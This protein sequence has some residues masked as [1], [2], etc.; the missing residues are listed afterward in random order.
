V[1]LAP[2]QGRALRVNPAA[3]TQKVNQ[4]LRAHRAGPNPVLLVRA[5]PAWSHDPLLTTPDGV[6]LRVV[7]CVSAL[8][9]WEQVSSA[10]DTGRVLLT[11]L[12][13]GQ[14]GTG[15]LSQVFR[16]RILTIESWDLIAECFGAQRLDPRLEAETWAGEA[17]IDAMPPGGWP[18]LAGTVLRRDL[19]LRYLAAARLGLDRLKLPP[20]DL[21][22]QALLLWSTLPAAPESLAQL[23]DAERT[24]LVGW[25][26]GEFGRPA[27]ALFA[28]VA[29][30]HGTDALAVGLVCAALWSAD[31]AD[32]LRAQ[33]RVDQYLGNG[34]L[35]AVTVRSFAD[36][37]TQVVVDLLH[38][39][40]DGAGDAFTTRQIGHTVLDRTEELLIQFG[41]TGAARHSATMRSGFEYRLGTVADALTAAL[42]RPT[43]DAVTAAATA[44]EALA[45]HHLA[46]LHGHRVERARMALRLVRWLGTPAEVASS[47]GDGIS[48]Q[49][50]DWSWADLA[51]SHVWTGED[52]H[53][54][55][56]RVYR[57]IHDRVRDRRR[58]LDR[59]FA[60]RLA[61]WTNAGSAAGDLLTV[62]TLLPRVVAPLVRDGSRGVLLIVIDGMSTAVAAELAEEL[63]RQSWVEYDPLAGKGDAA[64][65]RGVV[66]ALPT[67]T[68]VSRTS[69]FSAALRRDDQRDERAAFESHHL[70]QG[71]PAR[72]FHKGTVQGTAGEVLGEELERALSEPETLVGVVIN[73]VDDALDH[74]RESADAGWQ[75]GQ[76]GSLRTLLDH[77][78][79]HGRAVIITS[80]HG[81][82]LERDGVLKSAGTAGSARHRTDPAPAGE[83]EV[84]LAGPRVVADGKR[85]VALWDPQLRYLPRKAGYHGGASLAEVTIP[86]LAFLRL[87]AGT[88]NGWALV[89]SQQPP[90]WSSAQEVPLPTPTP[91]PPVPQKKP[92]KGQPSPDEVALFDLP[93]A[94]PA[95]TPA[96]AAPTL[97]DALLA[98]DMFGA[99]HGLTPR[100]VPLPKIRG[101]LEALLDANGV[102]P[103]IVVAQRA[104][105]QPARATGFLTTLQR[106]FNVDNFQVLSLTNDGRTVR[107]NVALLRAQFGLRDAG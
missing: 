97:V 39:L 53:G 58:E 66:A 94:T 10:R 89:G 105:E 1:T 34:H 98:S 17:L 22:A 37:A 104:G 11:D 55:L 68:A 8:A 65:R 100:K 91:T 72:L 3:L 102:L 62:E 103:T 36:T 64:R 7:P 50:D 26:V 23:R 20:E 86:L 70:W 88:P 29:A 52:V 84:E 19:A 14:L 73:T 25:L 54:G 21:D 27:R 46:D 4:Q 35:D 13:E 93:A 92:K 101:A 107:L 24:G 57:Q 38:P 2:P 79:Y 28:L 56:K 71:R 31:D 45:G 61:A 51:L 75:L 48:R 81:H 9:V 82:V 41:A 63:A 90:W 18:P 33:G 99:Q 43:P 69:L 106:I 74:G 30:G 12:T 87:G 16:Q 5:E 32:S 47:V 78:R 44:V 83:G 15:I 77:A 85:V 80:D 42:A 6:Q 76:L 95:A 60:G 59:A 40:N 67:L 49:V 96:P